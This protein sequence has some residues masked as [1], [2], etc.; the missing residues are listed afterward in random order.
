MFAYTAAMGKEKKSETSLVTARASPTTRPASATTWQTNEPRSLLS[1]RASAGK[2]TIETSVALHLFYLTVE[3]S[4]GESKM[5]R[6]CAVFVF[7][8]NE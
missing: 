6:A 1:S 2:E 7:G 5:E 3:S 4:E 8:I